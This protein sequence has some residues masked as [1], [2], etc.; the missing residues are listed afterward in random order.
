MGEAIYHE[1]VLSQVGPVDKGT[2]VVID[3]ETGDYELD[4]RDATAT[5]RLLSRRPTAVTYAVRVGHRAAYSHIGGF[6]IPKPLVRT[7]SGILPLLGMTHRNQGWSK[8]QG[9]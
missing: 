5:R 2:F 8:R 9:F 1:R 3:V 7:A 4:A 6:R